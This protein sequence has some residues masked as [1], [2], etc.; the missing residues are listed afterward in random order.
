MPRRSRAANNVRERS[1]QIANANIPR[2]ISTQA[3]PC[4]AKRWRSTSVSLS[5]R[6]GPGSE[7]RSSRKLYTSPLYVIVNGP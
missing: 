7:L 2:S 6:K 3:G 1:S 5:E 4:S